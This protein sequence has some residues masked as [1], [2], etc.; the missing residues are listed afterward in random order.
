MLDSVSESATRAVP[1]NSPRGSDEFHPGAAE[2]P[3]E[4]SRRNFL[5][6]LGGTLALAGLGGCNRPPSKEIVPYVS[7][8]EAGLDVETVYYASTLDREGFGRGVLVETHSGRPTKIEGNPSHP[9]SRGATDVF[10]QAAILTLYDPERSKAPTFRGEPSTWPAF[11][12]LWLDH[13]RELN[14]TRGAG[15]ALLTEPTASPTQL[16]LLHALLSRFPE[17]R[18]YQHTPLPRWDRAGR[19][20]DYSFEK[21]DVIFSLESDLLY[22]HPAA[23]RYAHAFASRRRVENGKV[24]ANRLYVAEASPSVTGS[25]A[26]HRL[27]LNPQGRAALLNAIARAIEG[28]PAI[29]GLDAESAHFVDRLAADLREHASTAA[30]VVG[31]ELPEAFHRWADAMN[32]RLGSAGNIVRKLPPVRS[33][34]DGR[35]AGD[36]SA[37]TRELAANRVKTLV[38]LDVNP[39]YTAPGDVLFSEHLAKAPLRI[40]LGQYAD[41]TAGLCDWHLPESHILET[42][43]D[44]AAFDG[45]VSLV[46]P[47]IEP[48]YSTVSKIELLHELTD[49][50]GRS[51]YDL[52]RETWRPRVS[53]EQFEERWR[54]WLDSEVVDVSGTGESPAS[55]ISPAASV[56]AGPERLPE[57]EAVISPMVVLKPDYNLLDGRWA[58]NAW[59]QE[60]PRPFSHLVWDNA[61]LVAPALARERGLSTGDTVALTCHGR[62]ILAP[63][64]IQQGQ[65][66]TTVTLHLGYGRQRAGGIGS[67]HG[68][69]A[70]PIRSADSPWE[71]NLGELRKTG[72]RHPF[73]STQG[74]FEM[75][76]RDL[77]RVVPV[78]EL[79]RTAR[80]SEDG[81]TLYPQVSYTGYAWGMAI[82]LSTCIGCNACVVACQAENNIPVVGK[83]QV[84]R[85]REML[86]LRIDRYYEGDPDNPRLLHQPVPCMHCETAPCEVVCPVGATVHSTEGL[87]EMVYNR[88]IGT[89]YC[90]NN[91]PYKVRRFNFLDYR[92]DQDSPVY[93][94]KNPNVTVRQRGVMEKCTYCVQRIN[95]A[96]IRAEKENRRIHD[97]EVT[98]ACQQACPVDAIVFGD[99]SDAGSAVVR[100]KEE[101]TNYGL[102]S[103]LNTRPRTTYLARVLN[104]AAVQESHN[105]A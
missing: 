99:L 85:G 71:A 15:F 78:S 26:D 20:A 35:C 95:A 12:A 39:A 72:K 59:L 17:A 58:P 52:V 28:H 82:D 1:P 24:N 40:H 45:T 44:S 2:W 27:P 98:T 93:L 88:C 60:L 61:A 70:Y 53:S 63:V 101:R 11:R 97:G 90:S 19:Q 49:P 42:W 91:C 34:G 77:V 47:M 25:M 48:L 67:A 76:G 14:A 4:L 31:P 18:W 83:E 75:E 94:Q 92:G 100:R 102:L 104:P 3:A 68:F 54:R 9:E 57:P 62:T 32:R 23:L 56:D 51:G 41:E 105:P 13:W 38:L 16:R 87:N 80:E 5:Q 6:L 73:V 84:A 103:E 7:P 37:L 81:P 69:D 55:A 86:W 36:L 8:P 30:I 64:W 43:S 89:R 33:D 21:A 96:R 22:H 46:Q 65:A 29:S 50:A 79:D 74:H 10:M 66:R